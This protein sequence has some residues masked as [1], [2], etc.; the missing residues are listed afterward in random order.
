M[1]KIHI[2]DEHIAN[3]IAAGEV[4]E[5]PASVVKELVENAIDAGSTKIEVTVEEGGLQSIR[6]TDNGSGIDPNDCTAAF[7][8]HA[9]SKIEHSRDL[10]H[11]TTLGFRGEALPSIAAV[12][13]VELVTSSGDEGLGHRVVIEGGKLI[14]DETIAAPRGTDLIIRELF[15]NTPARLKY[16]KTIQTEL[17]HISDFMYRMALSHPQI[18]FSLRHNSNSLL[19]TVGNGDLLQVIAAVYGTQAAKAM[20]P[21]QA[22]NLD[23]QLHGYIS[24]PEWTRSNRN[25]I[26][27]M[28]N[29]RYIRNF[30]VNQA[31]QRAYHTLLPINRFPLAVFDLRMH[32]SLVD[33]NVHPAKLEVRFSKEQ[34]LYPFVEQSIYQVLRQEVLIPQ[35]VKQS[36]GGKGSSS[37]IQEQFH[38]SKNKNGNPLPEGSLPL[39][40]SDTQANESA[41]MN[42][43]SGT[44]SKTASV[45]DA[46]APPREYN[47]DSNVPSSIHG[48]SR[49]I[50]R[51]NLNLITRCGRREQRDMLCP[52]KRI[53]I[54]VQGSL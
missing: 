53:E 45:V 10:F 43:G 17:G 15:Y 41:E 27:T 1:A 4:V 42:V 54:F 2:L 47:Q 31:I 6:V 48:T 8:R 50:H 49:S 33:V 38:F 11:I 13:K 16:M 22:E 30:G 51:L 36:I 23:F 44:S 37:F 14:A 39:L 19:Q 34:E 35:P 25:G 12:A 3:Q 7:Y 46:S 29:G 52:R 40:P 26:S 21:I 5:R 18:A 9:T 28:V 32:P 20:L 24:R